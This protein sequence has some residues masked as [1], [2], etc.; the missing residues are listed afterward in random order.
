MQNGENAVPALLRATTLLRAHGAA[1]AAE[2]LLDRLVEDEPQRAPEILAARARMYA[3]SGDLP[4][5]MTVLERGIWNI[6]TV[7]ICAMR[8]H[9]S[10]RNRDKCPPPCMN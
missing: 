8:R 1:A 6:R 5:A 3:D 9:R 4:R 2:E 7:S 10:T